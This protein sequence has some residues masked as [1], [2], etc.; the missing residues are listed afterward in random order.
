MAVS[1]GTSSGRVDRR[2][3]RQARGTAGSNGAAPQA[4]ARRV[5][6]WLPLRVRH[7]GWR[8][9]LLAARQLTAGWLFEGVAMST[10]LA[11]RS[12]VDHVGAVAKGL[13]TGLH[14]GPQRRGADRRPRPGAPRRGGRRPCGGRIRSAENLSD[15]VVAPLFWGV[16]A[17]LPGMLAYKAINTLDS[18]VGPSQRALPRFRLGQRPPRRLG[19]PAPARL[20]G[21]PPLPRRRPPLAAACGPCAATRRG[22]ARPMP[23]GPR[24]RWR[25]AWA[26]V[27]PARAS[28]RA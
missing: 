27:S 14:Q 1:P 9:H 5:A 7:S 2:R 8:A 24:P 26:C 6:C 17:G 11:Q 23:A 3:Y 25:L 22:I 18:M 15:G 12:L 13:R 16:V 21:A 20:T 28:T 19:Q 10:C 4:A